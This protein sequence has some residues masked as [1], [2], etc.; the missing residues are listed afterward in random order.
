MPL[1]FAGKLYAAP[2]P[3][4]GAGSLEKV[5]ELTGVDAPTGSAVPK[6]SPSGASP[7]AALPSPSGERWDVFEAGRRIVVLGRSGEQKRG[8]H[9]FT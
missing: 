7:T 3:L 2:P 1:A 5:R 9:L 6:S 4:R 8:S